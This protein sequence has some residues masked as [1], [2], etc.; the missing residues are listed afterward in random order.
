MVRLPSKKRQA[1][2]GA[3]L[4]TGPAIRMLQMALQH[5]TTREQFDQPVSNYQ[6]VQAMMADCQTEIFAARSAA[7]GETRSERS[8]DTRSSGHQRY[9]SNFRSFARLRC[10]CC[11][12][13]F[14][15]S[16]PISENIDGWE[17]AHPRLPKGRRRW[18]PTLQAPA[19]FLRYQQIEYGPYRCDS[20]EARSVLILCPFVRSVQSSRFTQQ[21]NLTT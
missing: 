9:D 7:L 15:V 17:C 21:L 14:H 1:E 19:L 2:R 13:R 3:C 16:S 4:S 18:H 10:A 5:A 20:I 12:C 8:R 11:A 6:L